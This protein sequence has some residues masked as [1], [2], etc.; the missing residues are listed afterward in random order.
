MTLLVV[1]VR[2]E[3]S[4]YRRRV[5]F[6]KFESS[7]SVPGPLQH[8]VVFFVTS[9]VVAGSLWK[10]RVRFEDVYLVLQS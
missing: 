3:T 9:R 7:C 6:S 8:H 1:D 2:Q 5:I 4:M 10:S